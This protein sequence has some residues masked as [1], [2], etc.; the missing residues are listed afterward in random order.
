MVSTTYIVFEGGEKIP[1]L[2]GKF[3]AIGPSRLIAYTTSSSDQTNFFDACRMPV[4]SSISTITAWKCHSPS[5][6]TNRTGSWVL[7]LQARLHAPYP[8]CL[9]ANLPCPHRSSMP[10]PA[11]KCDHHSLHMRMCADE[12]ATLGH[13]DASPLRFSRTSLPHENRRKYICLLGLAHRRFHRLAERTIDGRQK[14][15]PCRLTIASSFPSLDEAC[16]RPGVPRRKFAGRMM[17]GS[18]SMTRKYPYC[19]R[20]GCPS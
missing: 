7:N 20:Y 15:R 3:P 2:V 18:S 17:R 4:V 14:V 12:R 1:S 11:A 6:T 19:P 5:S 8:V 10:F 13:P 9:P 16:A